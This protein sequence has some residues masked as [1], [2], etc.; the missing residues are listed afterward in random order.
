MTEPGQDGRELVLLV[1]PPTALVARK[2]QN[3]ILQM[4]VKTEQN[5]LMVSCSE[6]QGSGLVTPGFWVE[7]GSMLWSVCRSVLPSRILLM[8]LLMVLVGSVFEPRTSQSSQN[9]TG[10]LWIIF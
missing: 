5:C 4:D 1:H 2:H 10:S 6:S 3:L 7:V 9:R 8:V